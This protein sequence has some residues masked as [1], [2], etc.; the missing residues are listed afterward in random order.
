VSGRTRKAVRRLARAV[1]PPVRNGAVAL[2]YHR[3]ARADVDPWRL[4]VDPTHLS[5][6][7]DILARYTRPTTAAGLRA[8]V[9]RGRVL[10]T[11]VVVTFDDGYADLA[12]DVAPRLARAGIPATMFL[13]S[14][15][16]DRDR[17]FWWDGLERALLGAGTPTAPLRL[18]I[19]GRVRRWHPSDTADAAARAAVHR[20][21]W[22]A[23]RAR[24]PEERDALVE[25]VLDWAGLPSEPRATQRTLRAA[26]LARLAGDGLVE[27]GAHTANHPWLAGLDP[28]RQR[29][30]IEDGRSELEEHVGRP[31][32][33][34]AY[35]HG[36]PDDVGPGTVDLVRR[37]GF[38]SAFLATPGRLGARRDVHILPRLFIEDMDGEA[39][40]RLLWRY[41]GIRVG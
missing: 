30:E 23:L 13:V 7:L 28:D 14:R 33:S 32:E 18:T 15:A 16:V 38:R 26:Q 12:T 21:V 37:A 25:A 8:A 29:R 41:A 2:L 11:T 6:H 36:G 17:E 3:A 22:T 39:F 27:I 35:P 19:D 24:P 40:G 9:D 5:E 10:P 20:S 34:F 31:V 4:A 1:G